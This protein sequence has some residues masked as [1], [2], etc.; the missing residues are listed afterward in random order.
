MLFYHNYHYCFN[1]IIIIIFK[2]SSSKRVNGKSKRH[3]H[4]RK[5]IFY[6]FPAKINNKLE[7]KENGNPETENGLSGTNKRAGHS[8]NKRSHTALTPASQDIPEGVTC[9]RPATDLQQT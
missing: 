2:L 3:F 5:A 9:N 6:Y 1:F 7:D 4:H 8:N